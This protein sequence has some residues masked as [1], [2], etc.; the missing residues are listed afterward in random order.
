M[1]AFAY[2]DVDAFPPRSPV[3]CFPSPRVSKIAFSILLAWSFRDMWRSIMTELRRRAV[4]LAFPWPAISGAEP[5]TAS[6]IEASSPIFPEGVKPRPPIRLSLT[7]AR[8]RFTQP[9]NR[10]GYHRISWALPLLCHYT[11][12]DQ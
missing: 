3:M 4:G 11:A 7:K 1:M 2:S 5:W 6:N 9:I 10:K 12:S 8:E